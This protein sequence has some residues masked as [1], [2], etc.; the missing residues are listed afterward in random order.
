MNLVLNRMNERI[1]T[2]SVSNCIVCGYKGELLYAGLRDRL[3]GVPGIWSFMRC[4]ECGLVWLNP[5]PLPDNIKKIYAL[6]YTHAIKD[7]RSGIV[8]LLRE[9]ERGL[10]TA[11]TGSNAFVH[12]R[13][14]QWICKVL[15]MLPPL[16]EKIRG[17]L[18]Y[19]DKEQKGKLLD[20]G[21]GNG[22]FL[23]LMK[24]LGWEVIGI[25]PDAQAAKMAQDCFGIPVKVGLLEELGFPSNYADV[26]TMKHVI[27][28]VID[29][30]VILGEC[31]RVLKDGGNLV[32]T[33]PNIE[34]MGSL[35]FNRNWHHLDPPRHLHLFTVQTLRRCIES[36]GLRIKEVRTVSNPA[37]RTWIASCLICRY[38]VIQGGI[39]SE[40]LSSPLFFG[41]LLFWTVEYL[42]GNLYRNFGEEIVVVATK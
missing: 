7:R 21:C 16:R 24:K 10:L 22:Y 40:H 13:S 25:E 34:S 41:G 11:L 28:H 35:Y 29:P 36:V 37:F 15:I 12:K 33:S 20:V 38:S 26:I 8:S 2:E 4:P 17:D 31:L 1:A 14:M 18:L 5:Q 32:V 9:L 19:L 6:Y 30:L 39:A 27:E 42:L 3:F 23:N